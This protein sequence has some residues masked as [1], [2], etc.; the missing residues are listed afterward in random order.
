MSMTTVLPVSEMG[1]A[2][3][4]CF[5]IKEG[6]HVNVYVTLIIPVGHPMNLAQFAGRHARTFTTHTWNV[7]RGVHAWA[8]IEKLRS[9]E[10]GK[11]THIGPGLRRIRPS[12]DIDDAYANYLMVDCENGERLIDVIW[13]EYLATFK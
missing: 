7:S 13:R 5:K 1:K 12:T 2:K 8:V 11:F 10:P 9:S 4:S 6:Y 3:I